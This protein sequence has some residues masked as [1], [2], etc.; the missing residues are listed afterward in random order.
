MAPSLGGQID[1]NVIE[2]VQ[3][4]EACHRPDDF[5]SNRINTTADLS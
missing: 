5:R 3:E 1:D 2:S 4:R